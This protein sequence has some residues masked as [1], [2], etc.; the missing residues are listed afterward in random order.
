MGMSS[1][2]RCAGDWEI[3]FSGSSELRISHGRT[4]S[5]LAKKS[6][7]SQTRSLTSGRC[8]RGSIAISSPTWRRFV[9]QASR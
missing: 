9:W 7:M 8:G 1:F 3:S 5:N 6:V 4:Y 2:L